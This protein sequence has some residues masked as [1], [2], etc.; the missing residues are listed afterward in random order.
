MAL[1]NVALGSN[2]T[3]DSLRVNAN[4]SV[5]G[6][7]S[8][9][10]VFK[11]PEDQRTVEV[12]YKSD[13]ASSVPQ[14]GNSNFNIRYA[15]KFVGDFARIGGA[16]CCEN[17]FRIMTVIQFLNELSS[18]CYVQNVELTCT[19][20]NTIDNSTVRREE[21][22]VFDSDIRDNFHKE[23]HK[24]LIVL[25]RPLILAHCLKIPKIG[26]RTFNI[27]HF[28]IQCAEAK[29]VLLDSATTVGYAHFNPTF[30]L[31]QLRAI[32]I[33]DPAPLTRKLSQKWPSWVWALVQ[34][35]P[36]PTSFGL[37]HPSF[38]ALPMSSE[39]WLVVMALWRWNIVWPLDQ[40]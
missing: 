32:G 40:Q 7:R 14:N 8:T 25:Y 19:F 12:F 39:L 21:L 18:L 6:R 37:A 4:T 31:R 1:E 28:S 2:C 38:A 22:T 20:K 35:A 15:R 10:V 34:S 29:S 9:P 11:N 5:C 30:S 33:F 36:M 24:F 27:H 13:S 3:L 16:I 26:A 17:L 23:L